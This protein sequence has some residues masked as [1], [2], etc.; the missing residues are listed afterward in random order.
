MRSEKALVALLRRLVQLLAE[1][2]VRNPEFAAKLDSILTTLPLSRPSKARTRTAR[3]SGPLP[4]VHAEWRA[5]GEADFRLWLR[6]QPIPIIRAL[7]RAQ[8]LD[9]TRR[10]VK[11]KEPEKL[12]D[13]VTESLRARLSRGSAFIGS[14]RTGRSEE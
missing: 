2:S 9:P 13:F 6:D 12:A 8:D 5:R 4:D 3:E 10:T 11:W 14:G 1:E 7:I